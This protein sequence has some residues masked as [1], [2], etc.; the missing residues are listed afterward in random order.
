MRI[1][2]FG[3]AC[4][5]VEH[6]GH[7]VVL[8]PG[9]F[10]TPDALDGAH[11]VLI[12]HEHPDHV[13]VDLLRDSD[14]AVFTIGAVA[15]KIRAESP[16]VAER[17]TVVGPGQ[18]FEAAGL[19][20]RTVGEL[21]AVIHAE[22]PRVF[23]CGYVVTAGGSRLYHPGDALEEPGEPV[24]VLCLPVSAPWMRASE[25][26]DFAR[27]VTAPRNLAIHDRVYSEFGAAVFDTHAGNFL[28]AAGL[29]YHR[30]A[31]GT[32]LP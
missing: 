28:P 30:L 11:A 29:A 1:T 13:A 5:R 20:V 3:H 18:V 22:Y 15:D 19:R 23:N 7:V 25:A 9:M 21:H 27:R 8:D 26:I 16:E 14:A 31:D 2:K 10:A 4:V 24:D 6:D 17:V 12:T 32:D